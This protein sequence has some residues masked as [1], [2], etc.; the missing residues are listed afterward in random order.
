MNIPR[1]AAATVK[2]AK[3]GGT[4]VSDALKTA[5]G[6]VELTSRLRGGI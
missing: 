3:K 2:V 5:V 1:Y 6:E 4:A